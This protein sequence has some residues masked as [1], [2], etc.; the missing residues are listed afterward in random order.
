MSTATSTAN[1]ALFEPLQIGAVSAPNR[2]LMAPLTRCRNDAGHVPSAPMAT[3]YAA[4]AA[5]GVIIAEGTV[6]GP[7]QSAFM[8]EPG[9][10]SAEQI[11]GWRRVTDA[12]HAKGGR[13]LAQV[14]HVGRAA[15]AMNNAAGAPPVAPSAIRITVPEH[16]SGEFNPTGEPIP[17]ETPRALRDD[18]L[19]GVLA[20]FV[21]AAKNAI[22][23]G[24]DGVEVHCANGYLLDSFLRE[25]SNQR[26]G[27]YGGSMERRARFPLEVVA[28]TAEAI[29]AG[30]VGVRISPLN[31]YQSMAEPDPVAMTA[32]FAAELSRLGIAFLHVLR[33]DFFGIQKGDV[34]KAARDN[35]AAPGVLI[36]NLGYDAAEA[37]AAVDAGLVDA[38]AFGTA[39]AANPDLVE[40]TRLGAALNVPRPQFF[41]TTGPEGY[42]DYPT[43]FEV[44]AA[45]AADNKAEGAATTAA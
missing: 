18:E 2:I 7:G 14:C 6:P 19:P 22:A 24:F 30:R 25:S 42:N 37:A 1:A 16:I 27:P 35:F 12:V 34:V 17:Y 21:T 43:L 28:A 26:E 20:E 11:A 8:H 39:F 3:H 31:S 15:T 29:G 23:A 32:H 5:A 10:Y 44:K 4:R 45:A 36:G 13:I 33:A 9:L 40:R 38:V 41:Y